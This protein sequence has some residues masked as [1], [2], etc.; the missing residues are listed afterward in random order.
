VDFAGALFVE[1]RVIQ[2]RQPAFVRGDT[3]VPAFLPI[4]RASL[5]VVNKIGNPGILRTAIER[6]ASDKTSVRCHTYA[7]AVPCECEFLREGEAVHYGARARVID[8][9]VDRANI[10][11]RF[12]P[13]D[14]DSDLLGYVKIVVCVPTQDVFRCPHLR[15]PVRDARKAVVLQI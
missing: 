1:F 2:F 4:H 14:A 13:K 7:G 8:Q 5:T 15:I 12:L 10:G 3:R 11:I 6:I 9:N